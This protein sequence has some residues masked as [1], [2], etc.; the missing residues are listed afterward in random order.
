[1]PGCA[2]LS[3]LLNALTAVA[4]LALAAGVG[5]LWYRQLQT[6]RLEALQALAAR[7]G[8]ALVMSERTL[9][10][11]GVLRLSPRG[12]HAWTVETRRAAAGT[13]GRAAEMQRTEFAAEDPRW[14]EG[15][16]IIGP[17][18]PPDAQEIVPGRTGS[19]D[20]PEIA[21]LLARLLGEDLSRYGAVLRPFPAPPGISV[22]ATS[23]PTHR[24]MLADFAKLHASWVPLAKGE[25]GRPVILLGPDGLRVRL[26]HGIRRADRMEAFIDFSLD[27]AR[28]LGH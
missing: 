23:D 15:L 10:R 12:G 27:V 17:A 6:A 26:R 20:T 18:L 5:V 2:A 24:V 1:M 4:F 8:W 9:G 22:F 13:Q 19:L 3:A 16:L 25:A 28:V 7:R 14:T 21:R 11:P